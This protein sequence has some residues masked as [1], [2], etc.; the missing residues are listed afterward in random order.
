LISTLKD[1]SPLDAAANPE[2]GNGRSAVVLHYT[3]IDD[4]HRFLAKEK[5]LA[6]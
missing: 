2:N 6:S 4:G 3:A 5:W 1:I